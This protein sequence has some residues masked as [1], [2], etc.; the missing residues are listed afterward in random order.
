M[1]LKPNIIFIMVDDLGKE[2]VS[3]Y[4]SE[5]SYTPNIDRLAQEGM[6]FNNAY[7]MAQCTPTRV[8]LL[9]GKYPYNSGWVNHWDVPR[10]G[11][12]YF[13]WDRYLTFAR[14]LKDEGYATAAA[15]KW[16]IND[17]RLEP[18]AMRKHGFD[19]W[20]MWTGY[21]AENPPSGE[22]YMDA[23]INTPEGSRTYDGQFGPDIF[24]DFVTD[25]LYEHKDKPMLIYYPMVLTHGPF[26]PTPDEPEV[27][28]A[29][30]RFAAM[31]RY[32]DKIVG[33][34]KDAVEA[35][36][37]ADNTILFF[38]TDNG[39]PG[40]MI[41]KRYGRDINGAKAKITEPGLCQPFLVWGPGL[42]KAGSERNALTAFVDM[43]PTFAE[44]GGA[45][46]PDSI[47]ID[48][49]SIAS[50]IFGKDTVGPHGWI[51]G[52][53]HG[54]ARWTEKGV[55]PKLDFAER[56]IR[57]REFKVIVNPDRQ[58]THLFNLLSDPFEDNNLLE[59]VNDY[60]DILIKFQAILD[61]MPEKDAWPQYRQRAANSWDIKLN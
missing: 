16:Q 52:M 37:I 57:D 59:G 28:G 17:F 54:P 7:S 40:G 44:L 14:I 8:S 39:S 10:W 24:S 27:K 46:L 45:E 25:F 9:T 11:S 3:C 6:K 31:V 2:W 23:Y 15:G 60:G 5:N 32:T 4:G 42:V 22:R 29:Q 33:K 55:A 50:V 53:G 43:L 47:S 20:C 19:D 56:S 48:G 21:E 1:K 26:V 12:G 30:N 61:S 49:R 35:A 13:D 34:I 36:G 41:G 18:E 51:M 58:I 38:T